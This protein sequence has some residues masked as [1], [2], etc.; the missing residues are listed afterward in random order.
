MDGSDRMI[1]GEQCSGVREGAGEKG[2]AP[3]ARRLMVAG[4]GG[5][6][7]LPYQ[8]EGCGVRREVTWK[9]NSRKCTFP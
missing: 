8:R 1:G 7:Y 5:A 4:S 9:R 6:Y 2:K 3:A